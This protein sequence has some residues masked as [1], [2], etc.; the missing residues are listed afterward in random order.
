MLDN[1]DGQRVQEKFLGKLE[2]RIRNSKVAE[3]TTGA[4]KSGVDKVRARQ[5]VV[6][7]ETPAPAALGAL[8]L[9]GTSRRKVCSLQTVDHNTAAQRSHTPGKQEH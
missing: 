5:T 4:H 2:G 3:S 1:P 9:L 6:L 8:A 7:T